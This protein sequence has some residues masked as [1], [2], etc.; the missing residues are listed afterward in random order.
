MLVKRIEATSLTHASLDPTPSL[1]NRTINGL[2]LRRN[3]AGSDAG[4]WT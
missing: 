4:F 1:W 3:G 2:P